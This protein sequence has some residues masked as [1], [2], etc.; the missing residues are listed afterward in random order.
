MRGGDRSV[1]AS[2]GRSLSCVVLHPLR[3]RSERSPGVLHPLRKSVE[4]PLLRATRAREPCPAATH[5]VGAERGEQPLA[6]QPHIAL[7]AH[8]VGEV[9]RVRAARRA[10]ERVRPRAR[11][12]LSGHGRRTSRDTPS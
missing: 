3:I 4:T 2:S 10:L 11:S 1:S 7:D 5:L 6:P 12:T 9:A 8:E